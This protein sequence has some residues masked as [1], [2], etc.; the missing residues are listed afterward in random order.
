MLGGC[1]HDVLHCYMQHVELTKSVIKFGGG[2]LYAWTS[3]TNG[4]STRRANATIVLV[5]GGDKDQHR[6]REYTTMTMQDLK[7]QAAPKWK[8]EDE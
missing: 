2:K 4:S 6:D 3:N 7:T 1:S 5:G 8:D